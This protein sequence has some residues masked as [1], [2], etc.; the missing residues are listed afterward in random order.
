MMAESSLTRIAVLQGFQKTGLG[1]RVAQ[2]FVRACGKS[3]LGL[4][5]GLSIAEMLL[6]PAMPS[7]TARAGGIFMPIINSLSLSAGS[8][9]GA[10]PDLDPPFQDLQGREA[11]FS[12]VQTPDTGM[13]LLLL[14]RGSK[15]YVILHLAGNGVLQHAF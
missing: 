10:L 7:T 14:P 3:S 5:Y 8:E 4:A 2:L 12:L 6:A 9:P 13:L 15:G 1:E 11:F